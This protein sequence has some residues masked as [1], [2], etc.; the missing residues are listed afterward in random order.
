MLWLE[1]EKSRAVQ[2]SAAFVFHLKNGL[3]D[4]HKIINV[5]NYP[6]VK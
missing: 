2:N 6:A 5:I 1:Y 4:G 3:F